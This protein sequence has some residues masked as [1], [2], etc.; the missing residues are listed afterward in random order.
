MNCEV[1]GAELTKAHVKLDG[2]WFSCWI[3]ECDVPDDVIAEGDELDVDI[4][5]EG[6]EVA[7]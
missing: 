5:Y 2:L 7:E 4:F 6:E 3:C 1:C